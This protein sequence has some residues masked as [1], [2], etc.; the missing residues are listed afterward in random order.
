MTFPLKIASIFALISA[1]AGCVAQLP[2]AS[3]E[4][5]TRAAYRD[6]A[7]TSITLMVAVTKSGSAAHTALM[8]NA[9]QRVIYDPAGTFY[10]KEVPER[11]DLHYG[12]TPQKLDKYIDYQ[13]EKGLKWVM[14]TKIVKPAV[15]EAAFRAAIENGAS[16]S[17]FCAHNS[18][19]VIS[20]T[21]GFENFPVDIMPKK[22][23]NAFAA[24]PG[25]TRREIIQYDER[26]DLNL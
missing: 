15:A 21:P 20:R 22:A 3:D 18:T 23:L 9:S 25:V 2:W 26:L 7:P 8:I 19:L 24:L 6:Q 4:R 12:I 13:S 16:M 11:A 14:L 1:L 10:D 5:V 17:G